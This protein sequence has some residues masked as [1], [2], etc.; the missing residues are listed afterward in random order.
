MR[1]AMMSLVAFALG[2]AG[3]AAVGSGPALAQGGVDLPQQ[4]AC[5]KWDIFPDATIRYV[6]KR[7]GP[8]TTTREIE[9][10]GHP[11]QTVYEAEGKGVNPCGSNT[12]AVLDGAVVVARPGPDQ[13][14]GAHLGVEVY[15]VRGDGDLGGDDTCRPFQLDCTTPE[16]T[17]TPTE[18]FCDSRNEFDVYH[19]ASVLTLVNP[20]RNRR[21]SFFEN[22]GSQEEG[23]E[24]RATDGLSAE[25]GPG[26]PPPQR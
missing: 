2:V 21:C 15:S 14:F 1:K 8:L 5:Y 19:G 7:K 13:T 26:S 25:P 10:F 3:A 18:W 20:R 9:K 4:A 24:A 11:R 17:P 23:V 6:V 16:I 12:M 22:G